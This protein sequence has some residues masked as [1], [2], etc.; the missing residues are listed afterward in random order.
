MK[1]LL[2]FLLLFPVLI[3]SDSTDK[4]KITFKLTIT[5]DNVTLREASDIED[6]MKELLKDEK[7]SIEIDVNPKPEIF[8]GW[9]WGDI[10]IT[11]V[12]DNLLWY[13]DSTKVEN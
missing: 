1:K 10:T 12:D 13:E 4:T 9:Q 2:L 5:Y 6:R 11:P 8:Q 3:L 7:C